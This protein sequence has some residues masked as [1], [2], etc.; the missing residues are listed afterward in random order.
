MVAQPPESSD[1]NSWFVALVHSG[2]ERQ[3]QDHLLAS[4][5]DEAFHPRRRTTTTSRG[6]MHELLV[7]VFRGYVLCRTFAF[8]P[9]LWHDCVRNVDREKQGLEP[10]VRGFIGGWPAD[11]VPDSSISL[12]RSCCD[13]DDIWLPDAEPE[14]VLHPPGTLLHAIGGPMMGRVYRVVLDVGKETVEVRD[15]LSPDHVVYI[16][17]ERVEPIKNDNVVIDEPRRPVQ[18]MHRAYRAKRR[19]AEAA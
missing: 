14:F 5:F 3:A 16:R 6:K 4:G 18:R 17:R 13:A 15:L 9:F 8:T 2:K 12:L 10:L 11:P 7:P 19:P 1:I